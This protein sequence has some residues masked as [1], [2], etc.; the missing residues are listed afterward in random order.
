MDDF[1]AR[2]DPF[3]EALPGGFR[4][5]IEIRNPEYLGPGYF[6]LLARHGVAHVFN[7]WSRMPE[8]KK[9]LEMPGAFTAD[10]TVVRALLSKGRNY[11]QAVQR[12][13]PYKLVQEPDHAARDAMRQ[14]AERCAA[15]EETGVPLRQ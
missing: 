10:F 6:G 7:A 9:Q 12:F 13:T 8:L 1:L 3:L 2:L 5:G 15:P 14:I 4:Y 11:E